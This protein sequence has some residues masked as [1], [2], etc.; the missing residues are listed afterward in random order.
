VSTLT[1]D[2]HCPACRGG[3]WMCE[4]HG[5]HPS[6]TAYVGPEACD[7]GPGVPCGCNPFGEVDWGVVYASVLTE[8]DQ[9]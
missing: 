2:P 9:S 3:G 5:T 6:S 4:E 8:G 1:I 7:G